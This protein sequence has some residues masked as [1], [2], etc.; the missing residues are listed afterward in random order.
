MLIVSLLGMYTE[1]FAMQ[2]AR[3][4]AKQKGLAEVMHEW[5]GA[6][7]RYASDGL[8]QAGFLAGAECLL[9]PAPVNDSTGLPSACG[10]LTPDITDNRYLPA[11]YATDYKWYSILY[12]QGQNYVITFVRPPT[13]SGSLTDP[14]AQ[15]DNG[16]SV[17]DVWRHMRNMHSESVKYGMVMTKF[18]ERALWAPD[19]SASYPLPPCEATCLPAG[20]VG[21][22]SA[23]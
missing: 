13:N 12:T 4:L 22:I 14:I 21:F 5:H 1:I 19:F 15:P 3:M 23:L 6:A 18:T 16:F 9:T 10:T 20:S 11:G 8:S 17:N 2:G 7:F